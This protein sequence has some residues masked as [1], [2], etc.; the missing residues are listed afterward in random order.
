MKV[1]RS[2]NDTVITKRLS[3]ENDNLLFFISNDNERNMKIINPNLCNTTK[4]IVIDN[5]GV[6]KNKQLENTIVIDFKNNF[7]YDPISAL[8]DKNFALL[9]EFLI[10]SFKYGT[11]CNKKEFAENLILFFDIILC[12]LTETSNIN[13][14]TLK[15][16]KNVLQNSITSKTLLNKNSDTFD[17]LLYN[18]E[19]ETKRK[20]LN[21]MYSKFQNVSKRLQSEI[22]LQLFNKINALSNL[23]MFNEKAKYLTLDD[24]LSTTKNVIIIPPKSDFNSQFKICDLLLCQL[25]NKLNNEMEYNNVCVFCPHFD[26]Y[27]HNYLLDICLAKIPENMTLFLFIEDLC[28]IKLNIGN[29]IKIHFALLNNFF[30]IKSDD[31]NVNDAFVSDIPSAITNNSNKILLFTKYYEN[32]EKFVFKIIEEDLYNDIKLNE[33][34]DIN[35]MM[36]Q[37]SNNLHTKHKK[38]TDFNV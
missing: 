24:I 3:V 14:L 31:K 2:I 36:R 38:I 5:D 11:T 28:K 23:E 18:I 22:K 16:L 27:R 30:Y 34:I 20:K 6:Y 12:Y 21:E 7:H 1:S 25:L 17:K 9:S 4:S 26:R 10:S 37:M 29:N 8:N 32:D 13:T 15:E 35:T 19:N 33:S